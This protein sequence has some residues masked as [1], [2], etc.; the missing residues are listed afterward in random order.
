MIKAFLS[1]SSKQKGFVSILAR[2]L[3]E[4][5]I[6]YDMMTFDAGGKNLDEIYKA[7][8]RSGVFVFF[9]SKES[10]ESIWVKRELMR[11]EELL[12]KQKLKRFLPIIIDKDINYSD[13]RIPDWIR[14]YN[15][16]Y[17]SKPSYCCRLI[18]TSIITATWDLSPLI[19]KRDLM[20]VGRNDQ[21]R[22]FEERYYDHNLPKMVCCIVSGLHSI[23]RRKFLQHVETKTN[24]IS[25]N[26]SHHVV[27][28][29][30]RH[31]I[32]DLLSA[33]FGLGFTQLPPERMKN[34]TTMPLEEKVTLTASLIH[35][36]AECKDV[37]LIEDN[38]CIVDKRG[39]L[40][41]WFKDLLKSIKNIKR[42]ALCIV[43][44]SRVFY[45]DISDI[46]ETFSMDIPE[47]EQ[48]E[49]SAL[50]D[51]LLK[52][53][54][55]EL[56][57]EDHG[58][59]SALFTG[60][61]MQ[62]IQTVQLIKQEKIS[63]VLNNLDEIAHFGK[64]QIEKVI[65]NN[66]DT[67][68][69]RQM[70]IFLS[71]QDA[72]SISALCEIFEDPKEVERCI[73]QL[74]NC[75]LVEFVGGAGDYVRL[76]DIAKDYVQRLG[77]TLNAKY[78]KNLKEHAL[79]AIQAYAELIERDT[80]DYV[81]S[82]KELLKSGQQIPQEILIPSQ[83]V[84][85]MR[86]VYNYD[87]RYN[88]VITL[89]DRILVNERYLDVR[90]AH[91]IRYWLCLALSRKRDR[92]LLSEV[93]KV[94]G[95][96]HHFLLG[97][98]YRMCG[99]NQ[100]AIKSLKRAID[101]RS[102][103]FSASRELVQ[104]YLNVE[105]YTEAYEIAE[106]IYNRKSDNPYHIQS[107]IRC[108]IH[109]DGAKKDALIQKL[110]QELNDCQQD[111]AS[112][113]YLTSKAQYLSNIKNDYSQALDIADIAIHQFPRNI[114]PYLTKLEIAYKSRENDLIKESI[115]AADKQFGGDNDTEIFQ[116]FPYIACK[117]MVYINAGEVGKAKSYFEN[118][119]DH[120]FS[121]TIIRELKKRMGI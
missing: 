46:P 27:S 121:E 77:E 91:E 23:G 3:D 86:E 90:M 17:V 18:R 64:I 44:S 10:L 107:Y 48:F 53:E 24:I 70:L 57:E 40:A 79:K 38:N 61:P 5:E 110:L 22:Q 62:V 7:L 9:I 96:D 103:F 66:Q 25:E 118:N 15:L 45:K 104:A 113:M 87:K 76:N 6:E 100:D 72:I 34:L 58:V 49:R 67:D 111:K 30:V 2:M 37:L 97:F 95:A 78:A 55:I 69:I 93:Q 82:L 56:A 43:S 29:N 63:Y 42:L 39:R 68:L 98:Y 85:A 13:P 60:F 74:A 89:A 65:R 59:I 19:K 26:Y 94:E 50:F 92:R 51:Q 12:D 83:Y 119:V 81:L 1:H 109:V 8:D 108:L 20:F 28:L 4:T 71:K 52:I 41:E 47:L 84:N 75:F 16:K 99:R 31:S 54:N 32:E 33:L 105:Q 102:G 73:E 101:E 117:C 80:S 35:E 116:K 115:E 112:E 36:L 88:Q 106:D 14:D 11:A 21:I 114:Y 120:H